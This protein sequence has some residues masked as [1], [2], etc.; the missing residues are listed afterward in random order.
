MHYMLN[1]TQFT[2]QFITFSIKETSGRTVEFILLENFNNAFL[3][4]EDLLKPND[5]VDVYYYESEL[6]DATVNKFITF[7]VITDIIKK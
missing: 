7:K 3:L 1:L 2:N 6:F 5:V 4:T